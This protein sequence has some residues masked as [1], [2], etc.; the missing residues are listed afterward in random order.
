MTDDMHRFF[1]S[2]GYFLFGRFKSALDISGDKEAFTNGFLKFVEKGKYPLFEND[3][4]YILLYKGME[5]S[6]G[7]IGDMSN[8]TDIIP[9]EKI[10]ESGLYF[11]RGKAEPDARFE[12]WLM[13]SKN[14]FPALDTL[15]PYKGLS[16]FGQVSELAM[17]GY[18]R[19]HYF[20]KYVFGEKGSAE[21]L[22]THEI[23]SKY[24]NYKHTV[25]V[26]LPPE[27]NSRNT[28]PAVYFQDGIDYVE[29]AQVPAILD[30]LIREGKIRPLIAVF[31]TPP[32]RLK[33]GVPNRMTEYGLNDD[34]VNFFCYEL[35]T[36]IDS[37][38]STIIDPLMRLVAGDSYGG[39]ISAYIPFKRPDIFANGY[40]QSGYHSFSKDKLI[41][42]FRN[43]ATKGINLFV[44][45][46]LYER[47]V[48][49]SF[50]PKEET[51]FL[52]ANRRFNKVLEEKSYRFIYREYPEGH[53]WGN[54]K[55][56]LIDALTYFFPATEV[57]SK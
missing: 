46:G 50:L 22:K 25:H 2:N 41:E 32:N 12:Y 38:Y 1:D 29:F 21:G 44:D 23:N 47:N 56:H 53:T 30:G 48:G 20:D 6:V 40:S 15:N 49:A 36:M 33:P 16:G 54:W 51:D 5:D 34:Y 3:S 45:S 11:L 19:H 37:N 8:W 7:I 4:T 13:F 14:G 42:L 18:K 43:E 27:Y 17:P 57:R 31:V 28:Y 52:L 26:Y 9:M 39:L 55:R 35:V 10:D 24:L